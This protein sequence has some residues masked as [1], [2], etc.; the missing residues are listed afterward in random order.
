MNRFVSNLKLL[1][2]LSLPAILILVAGLITLAMAFYWVTVFENN[3]SAIVD[4]HAKRLERALTVVGNLNQATLTQRDLRL[5]KQ[6]DAAEKLA[7]DYREKLLKVGG[8][9]DALAPLMEDPDQRRLVQEARDAFAR[10][11]EVGREQSVGIIEGLKTGTPPPG[12][13][14]GRVWRDKVDELLGRIVT[15]SRQDMGRAKERGIAEG[16]WAAVML[17]AVS[18]LAVLAGLGMLAWIAVVQVAR[19]LGGMAALMSRLASGDLTVEV[20]GAERRDEVG[21]LARA[22]AV[23]KRTA[24]EVERTRADRDAERE[25]KVARAQALDRLTHD[26]EG[27]SKML[28]QSL[29]AAAGQLQSAAQSMV[30]TADGASRQS[31][32]VAAASEEASVNVETVAS[33]TEELSASIR[34]IAQQVAESAT[35]SGRAA[36]EA[37]HT[38]HTV[39]AL[40]DSAQKIG[41]VVELIN[42]IAAQTNLLALNATI[43]AARAGEAGKGFAVVASEVKTLAAQTASATGEIAGQV[44]QIQAATKEAVEVIGRVART[45]EEI[46]RIATAIAAAVEEQ[47]AATGDI[48]RS[49]TQAAR[50]TRDVSA[51][52]GG[53]RQ[54]ATQTRHDA[55][56]VLT[57][58]G[59][60]SRQARELTDGLGAFLAET[61]AA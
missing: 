5:V 10:F 25:A 14:K 13:G 7:A 44:G 22:L 47:G 60:L 45:I 2:K 59:E 40:A 42:T 58:A 24:L 61:K 52:V 51:N 26:F 20:E 57:A 32:T 56:Q 31:T 55:E 41:E 1:H 17:V 30:G 23:F 8:E 34:D 38:D 35:I 49:V 18:S 11:L 16:R 43:E 21:A 19:P 54:A 33:A 29:S 48:A 53:L 27:K 37:K 3:V 39:T 15:L 9:L 4:R 50:G 6:V 36:E 28:A 12:N 46:N